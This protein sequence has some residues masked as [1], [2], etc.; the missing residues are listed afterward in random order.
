MG[1]FVPRI[2][3]LV[4]ML[5]APGALADD[6]G[7]LTE[8]ESFDGLYYF[9]KMMPLLEHP[10][11]RNCHGGFDVHS[12][13]TEHPG[14]YV[15]PCANHIGAHCPECHDKAPNQ[16]KID[17]GE[18]AG[19]LSSD[20]VPPPPEQFFTP[21]SVQEICLQ[22]KKRFPDPSNQ[23]S[24]AVNDGR[25]HIG[26]DAS[27]AMGDVPT[28]LD[29]YPP[30]AYNDFVGFISD[31]IFKGHYGCGWK[32]TITVDDDKMQ[33]TDGFT[34]MM[35]SHV[36]FS[37]APDGTATYEGTSHD[38]SGFSDGSANGTTDC[39]GSGTSTW[40]LILRGNGTVELT[41]GA[42]GSKCTGYACTFGSCMTSTGD[43]GLTT[44]PVQ[45]FDVIAGSVG[46][47]PS[48]LVGSYSDA[49][50]N[51]DFGFH[52]VVTVSWDLEAI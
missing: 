27:H 52:E 39:N 43:G 49:L 6:P 2:A 10:R 1:D 31:W 37:V 50:D 35:N 17:S 16:F 7:P 22:F 38:A 36:V 20:W 41:L 46:P 28:E 47:D 29:E 23:Y 24:H 5:A 8:V 3:V 45:L 25:I 30:F 19:V 48:H 34:D 40:K 15:P 42:A 32:G 13:T 11:C 4:L 26:F 18:C 14:G 33:S 51:S 21:S 12:K 9:S 44:D